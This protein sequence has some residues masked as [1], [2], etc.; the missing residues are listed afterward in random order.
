MG[1]KYHLGCGLNYLPGYTNVDFPQESHSII[2]IKAD[3]YANLL[4]MK[5]EPCEEIRSHHVFEHFNYIESMALL[6]R[7]TQVL[8]QNGTLIIDVPDLE[9]LCREYVD[10]VNRRHIKK[11]FKIIRLLFGS[12]ESDW[13]YHINGWSPLTLDYVLEK[14][15]YD[16]LNNIPYGDASSDFPNCGIK[17]GFVKKENKND[18]VM[19]GKELL[20][21]YVEPCETDLYNLFCKQFEEACSK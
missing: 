12:H 3:I 19:K 2:T 7:W 11:A 4:D 21:Y 5:Y 8:E 10:A 18:L 20:K 14:F 1:L 15:G 17:M 16:C 13:A 6:V 9:V